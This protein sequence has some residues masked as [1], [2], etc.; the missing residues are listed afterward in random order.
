[1]A[2]AIG[3][4]LGRKEHAVRVLPGFLGG[5]LHDAKHVFMACRRN[6]V[7]LKVLISRG[8]LL[9]KHEWRA[10]GGRFFLDITIIR[11]TRGTDRVQVQHS[12]LTF[13]F[14][15]SA[16][17]PAPYR[18]PLRNRFFA[19]FS[20]F[21]S[22]DIS[23]SVETGRSLIRRFI[24][25][26]VDNRLLPADCMVAKAAQTKRIYTRIGELLMHC[27]V[28]LCCVLCWLQVFMRGGG[29]ERKE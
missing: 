24:F 29:A 14:G 19:A 9:Q 11:M 28:L 27:Y 2:D 10:R 13:T 7:D 21:L 25:S 5:V 18:A 1:M 8:N 12:T 4:R 23:A 20:A 3:A 26:F 22:R 17:A 6:T 15:I 16:R